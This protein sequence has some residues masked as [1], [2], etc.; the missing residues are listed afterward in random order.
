M[1]RTSDSHVIQFSSQMRFMKS[2]FSRTGKQWIFPFNHAIIWLLYLSSYIHPSILAHL[3]LEI[4]SNVG[5]GINSWKCKTEGGI[6]FGM[7]VSIAL[8]GHF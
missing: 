2:Y 8:M 1:D 4:G 6:V 5:I 7:V 3:K